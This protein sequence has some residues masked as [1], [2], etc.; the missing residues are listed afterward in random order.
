M[1][2]WIKVEER[3]P[4]PHIEVL[5]VVQYENGFTHNKVVEWCP[6]SKNFE[7][8]HCV[9]VCGVT[10]WQPLPELPKTLKI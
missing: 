7:D 8:D 2:N 3:M 6:S 10:H 4:E 1:N 9:W 5:A